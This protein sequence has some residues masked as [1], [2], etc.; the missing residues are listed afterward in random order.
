[1]LDDTE[2][3]KLFILGYLPKYDT[4]FLGDISFGWLNPN[5]TILFEEIRPRD[6]LKPPPK[7]GPA[8][9]FAHSE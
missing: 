8:I 5:A 6:E 1:V 2:N 9:T 3:S 7:R 4:V